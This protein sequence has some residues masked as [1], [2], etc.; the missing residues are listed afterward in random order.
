MI[1]SARAVLRTADRSMSGKYKLR[2][3]VQPS[4]LTPL[5]LCDGARTICAHK[6]STSFNAGANTNAPSI[7]PTIA[8]PCFL[9]KADSASAF[10]THGSQA[11]RDPVI[12]KMHDTF[13]CGTRHGAATLIDYCNPF[14]ASIQRALTVFPLPS[15]QPSSPRPFPMRY[16]PLDPIRCRPPFP[17]W[18]QTYGHQASTLPRR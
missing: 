12:G 13:S 9:Q 15:S 3:A 10:C 8:S 17:R 5:G 14:S 7:T 11:D 4:S 16:M 18:R 2:L 6:C 1:R